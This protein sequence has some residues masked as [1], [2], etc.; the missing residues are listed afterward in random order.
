MH[1]SRA[2][3]S[4]CVWFKRIKKR[5]KLNVYSVSNCCVTMPVDRKYY[6]PVIYL[7]CVYLVILRGTFVMYAHVSCK[8]KPL[9]AF[10][11][12]HA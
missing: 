11:C 12:M 2:L 9:K 5:F 8:V 7:G 3:N 4:A 1:F 6:T 10:M